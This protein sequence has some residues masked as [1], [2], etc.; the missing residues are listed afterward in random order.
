MKPGGGAAVLQL[1]SLWGAC[2]GA[3]ALESRAGRG[4]EQRGS[5]RSRG[6]YLGAPVGRVLHDRLTEVVIHVGRHLAPSRCGPDAAPRALRLFPSRPQAPSRGPEARR[7][8]VPGSGGRARQGA[9]SW[10]AG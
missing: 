2:G 4:R 6:G 10:R 8:L 9:G 5:W 3:R 1:G 7:E